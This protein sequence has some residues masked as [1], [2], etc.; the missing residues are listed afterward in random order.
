MP[1]GCCWRAQILA[2]LCCSLS[3]LGI[4][5]NP[6]GRA[7]RVDE[8]GAKAVLA[9]DLIKVQL[10]LAEPAEQAATTKVILRSSPG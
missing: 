1:N 10:P 6:Q 3:I 7:L 4:A 5:Q 2:V 9:E 8:S